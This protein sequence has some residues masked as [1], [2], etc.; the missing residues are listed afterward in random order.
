MSCGASS[1]FTDIPASVVCSPSSCGGNAEVVAEGA[2]EGDLLPSTPPLHISSGR[3]DIRFAGDA[4]RSDQGGAVCD[5]GKV[6]HGESMQA[7]REGGNS[8]S[9]EE[10]SEHSMSMAQ[11]LDVRDEVDAQEETSSPLHAVMEKL[12]GYFHRHWS[13]RGKGEQ[14]EGK[15]ERPPRLERERPRRGLLAGM[16]KGHVGNVQMKL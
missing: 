1:A 2:M 4:S 6:D 16:R 9:G 12:G 10:D 14:K 5:A 11:S 15:E 13:G 3:R 8:S 7:V